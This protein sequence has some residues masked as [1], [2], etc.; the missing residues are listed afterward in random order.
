[1][2]DKDRKIIRTL[3]LF[4]CINSR[5][6]TNSLSGID[7]NVGQWRCPKT[8]FL[9]LKWAQRSNFQKQ[10]PRN[11]TKWYINR[12]VQTLETWRNYFQAM[13]PLWDNNGAKSPFYS[14]KRLGITHFVPK[15]AFWDP[16]LS[17]IAVISWKWVHHVP[18]LCTNL[19]I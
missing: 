13:S 16:P 7:S 14:L 19:L 2:H 17:H 11:A 5:D 8:L 15:R 1:M 12:F 6:R 4:N 10:Q 18:R 9:G 3:I